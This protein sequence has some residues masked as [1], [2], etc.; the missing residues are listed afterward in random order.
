MRKKW[1]IDNIE[2]QEW[3]TFLITGA[4]SWL[5]FWATKAL[6]SKWA[7]IIMTSRNK[8]RWMEALNKIKEEIPNAK[9]DL[10][11]LDLADLE[12]VKKFAKE[13]ND[14]YDKLDVL[15]NNAWVMF[16]PVQTKTKQGFE[17]QF[18]TNH[19]W[20]FALTKLLL[21]TLEKT[22]NSRIV[23]MSSLVATMK[24]AYIYWDDLHFEKHYDT[25]KSYSQSKLANMIFAS[26]LN[27]RLQK[28]NSNITCL[29]AHPGYTATNLQKNMWV[30][31]RIM[32]SIVAQNVDMWILPMLR[33]SI[34]KN[35]K[36]WEYY[37][38]DKMRNFKGYPILNK[39]NKILEDEEACN[40]LWE[41]SEKLTNTK[42]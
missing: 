15:I 26:E 6:A 41:I 34:D 27:K 42:Y 29:M 33:A 5:W 8:E 11:I 38:P 16:P 9:L 28:N 32:T 2:S 20:H 7:N 25:M 13:F 19:L 39:T 31:W 12:N 17:L 36:W 3:K 37:G 35:V 23:V 30:L 21:E 18:W 10:M 22:P 1:T 4:N 24:D 14:K 40:K